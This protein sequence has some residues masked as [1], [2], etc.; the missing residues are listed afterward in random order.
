MFGLGP[1]PISGDE[2]IDRLEKQEALFFYSWCRY[3]TSEIKA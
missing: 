3:F 2:N 1:S